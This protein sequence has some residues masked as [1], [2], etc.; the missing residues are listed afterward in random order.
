MVEVK[1]EIT[2]EE[3]EKA[4]E[5]GAGTLI[6]EYWYMSY[7]VYGASVSEEDGKYYLTWKRGNSCD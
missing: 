1:S 4:K 5:N 2:K 6:D 7:G 3:Y